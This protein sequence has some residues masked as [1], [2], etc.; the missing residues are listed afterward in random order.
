MMSVL[1]TVFIPG[2]EV[3]LESGRLNL[4]YTVTWLYLLLNRLKN[5]VRRLPG[6]LGFWNIKFAVVQAL[7]YIIVIFLKPGYVKCN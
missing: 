5:S 3:D 7:T 2:V 4:F 6:P 1:T